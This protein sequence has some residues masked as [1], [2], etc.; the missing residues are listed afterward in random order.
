MAGRVGYP[1]CRMKEVPASQISRQVRNMLA[2]AAVVLFLFVLKAASEVTLQIAL[3]LLVFAFVNPLVERLTRLK[4]PNIV[5]I[6]LALALVVVI[7]FGFIYILILMVNML[8]DRMPY[9]AERIR[10]LDALLSSYL[11]EY[12]PDAG[13]DFSILGYV[14]VDWYGL[15]TSWLGSF[16]SKVISIFSDAM[17]VF[18][19]LIFLLLERMTFLPKIAFAFPRDKSQKFSSMLGRINR[20]MTKYLLLKLVISLI[21]GFLYYLTALVTG[22]DFALVWGVLATLLNFI[23]TIGSIIVT[24]LTIIMAIIQFA[25]TAWMNV[26]YVIILTVSIEMILGN[27][28]DPRIQ[29]VQLNMSPLMILISLSVWGYIWDLSPS[30]SPQARA[31]YGNTVC[32]SRDAGAS[33]RSRTR[34][35][36]RKAPRVTSSSRRG[37]TRKRSDGFIADKDGKFGWLAGR[38]RRQPP[39]IRQRCRHCHHGLEDLSADCDGA[40]P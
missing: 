15:A 16:S 34:N 32:R 19:T 35:R 33:A 6:T 9:Y 40:V 13:E 23:P 27:I 17:M 1:E 31:T 25:P 37:T 4:V 5:A 3:A 21:T 30:C 11:M 29:G 24:A 2:F 36:P 39:R 8:V 10:S 28:I 7:F 14:S 12:I 18:V 20:Q 38:D 26:V 22:L